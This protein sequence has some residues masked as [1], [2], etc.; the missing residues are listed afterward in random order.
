[1]QAYNQQEDD[2]NVSLAVLIATESLR[3]I[4]R[5][6]PNYYADTNRFTDFFASQLVLLIAEFETLIQ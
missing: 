1:V 5:A 2:T 3:D 6:Y 4:Q